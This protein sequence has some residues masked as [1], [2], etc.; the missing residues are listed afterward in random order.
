MDNP[1]TPAEDSRQKPPAVCRWCDL[2]DDEHRLRD[3]IGSLHRYGTPSPWAVELLAWVEELH[4][5]Y[6]N[7]RDLDESVDR[8][9]VLL[10]QVSAYGHSDRNEE[11]ELKL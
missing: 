6:R 2:E 8:L 1:S 7:G 5:D 9:K 10:D 4:D 11:L 3:V